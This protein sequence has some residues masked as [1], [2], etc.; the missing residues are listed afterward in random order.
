M[1][2]EYLIRLYTTVAG[3]DQLSPRDQASLV[4]QLQVGLREDGQ[5]EAARKDIVMLLAKLRDREDI[6]YRTRTDVDAI[7]ASIDA[8]SLPQAPVATDT[9][10]VESPI[11]DAAKAAW[12][13]VAPAEHVT[14]VSGP[15]VADGAGAATRAPES[16]APAEAAESSVAATQLRPNDQPSLDIESGE[17]PQ[18]IPVEPK[19]PTSRGAV[20]TLPP[21]SPGRRVGAA[22]I[23]AI[24]ILTA[25][26]IAAGRAVTAPQWRECTYDN[27][28]ISGCNFF[29]SATAA[30][31]ALIVASALVLV[32]STWNWGYRQG[33]TGSSIGKSLLGYKVVSEETGQPTGPDAKRISK[34]AGFTVAA[35]LLGLGIYV[36]EVMPNLNFGPK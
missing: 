30:W 27:G 7:L 12:R 4:A 18:K 20:T 15:T 34:V 35:L 22:F 26:G 21:A 36:F 33:K 9:T 31:T 19:R 25:Y 8:D 6:T 5:H 23:D 29:Y 16:V 17:A 10:A 14:P 32:Y 28:E 3:P 13:T 24:P 2:F 11:V 1:P